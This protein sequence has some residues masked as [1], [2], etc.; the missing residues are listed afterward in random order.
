M[1]NSKNYTFVYFARVQNK[2]KRFL[3]YSSLYW[4][5]TL[6]RLKYL[7]LSYTWIEQD[8]APQRILRKPENSW[9]GLIRIKRQKELLKN[10]EFSIW[11]YYSDWKWKW[12]KCWFLS[13]FRSNPLTLKLRDSEAVFFKCSHM[14]FKNFWFYAQTQNHYFFILLSWQTTNNQTL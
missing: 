3:P 8:A 13:N 10:K 1:Q 14:A 6:G 7:V 2:L 12:N 11:V 5:L 4:A 9:V